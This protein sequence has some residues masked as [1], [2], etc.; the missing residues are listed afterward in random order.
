VAAT[1]IAEWVLSGGL[2]AGIGYTAARS[3]IGTGQ[4]GRLRLT[5]LRRAPRARRAAMEAALDDPAF[6]P[7]RIQASVTE[8]LDV[9]A[10][11]WA[12]RSDRRVRRRP[13]GRRIQAWA[14]ERVSRLG[15]PGLDGEP[16]IDILS[17]V[18]RER[19]AEDQVVVRVRLRIDRGSG[20]S[21][22]ARHI[23]LDERWTLSHRGQSWFLA[24]VAGD[25]LSKSLLTAPLI[26]SQ[27][28]DSAR[29]TEAS[30]RELATDTAASD[31]APAEL[32]DHD[33]PPDRQLSDLAVADDRFSPLL[34]GAALQHL[35]D[36]WG[37]VGDGSQEPLLAVATGSAVHALLHPPV[38]RGGR[39]QVRDVT[40]RHWDVT[41]V[42][43]GAQPPAV[44]VRVELRAVEWGT[45]RG[46][47]YG[48]DRRSRRLKLLWTLEL[49]DA[50]AGGP[51]WRLAASDDA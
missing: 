27:Q 46:R 3:L 24:S 8:I 16:R 32:V 45:A 23:A 38:Y 11:V 50:R 13:D 31:P 47:R 17:V 42:D 28:S 6:A 10:A 1:E 30:L 15:D 7:E 12:N 26:A 4:R 20:I 9:A 49:V 37:Q 18:N 43:A 48:D 36:A 25:P 34:L 14:K 35:V 21:Y 41:A 44:Q 33:A 2:L 29:L 22:A 5:A 51:Q 19:D 39:R 40:L